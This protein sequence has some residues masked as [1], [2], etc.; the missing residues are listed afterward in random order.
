MTDLT[1]VN[2]SIVSLYAV[3]RKE[4]THKA[5]RTLAGNT[6]FDTS[7]AQVRAAYSSSSKAILVGNNGW[8]DALSGAG[9][10]GALN[11]PIV[12]TDKNSLNGTTKALLSELG[13]KDV[14]VIGGSSV[15]SDQVLSEL[16]RLGIS[17]MRV[18]GM[19]SY[20]TQMEVYNYGEKRGLWGKDTVIVATGTGFADALSI[21]PVAFVKNAPI[22]LVDGSKDLT[23]RQK[24]ALF[25]AT[26]DGKFVQA[27][28]IGGTGAVSKNVDFSLSSY[29]RTC[30]RI[31]GQTLYDTSAEVAEWAA[32]TS[33]LTWDGV[34]FTTGTGPYDAL[35]GSVLQGK[36]RSVLLLVKNPSSPTVH[37]ASFNKQVIANVTFFGGEIV[38]PPATKRAILSRLGF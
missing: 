12:F 2:R 27:L 37:R 30:L 7:A 28:V 24:N 23:Q 3:W 9:L 8:Q 38:M 36:T 15:V 4:A 5:S 1:S 18:W 19:R 21:A 31:A 11:C 17:S 14:V 35:S 10:A 32:D 22:F 16:A 6:L 25:S 20:D 33:V 34:A 13:V 26:K 29:S